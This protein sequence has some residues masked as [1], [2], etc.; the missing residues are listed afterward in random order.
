M[1][2]ESGVSDETVK[3]KI[4]DVLDREVI[5]DKPATKLIGVHNPTLNAAVVLGGGQKYLVGFGPKAMSRGLYSA[6]MDDF[7]ALPQVGSGGKINLEEAVAVGAE[8]AIVPER[9]KEQIEAFENIG[10]PAIAIIP[11]KESLS[12][13][14]DTLT[15][16]GK[17]LGERNASEINKFDKKLLMQKQLRQKRKLN[18]RCFSRVKIHRYLLHLLL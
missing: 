4:T 13:V 9:H 1:D 17:A 15:I 3:I 10:L 16:L 6:V 14:K 7:D 2:T 8:L 12:A 5:L 18:Q 11:S